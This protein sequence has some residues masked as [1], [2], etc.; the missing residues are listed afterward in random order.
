MEQLLHV[1][2]LS[3]GYMEGERVLHQITFDVKEGEIVALLGLNGAGKST[4]IKHILGFMKP[5]SGQIRIKGKTM[6]E[7]PE[8]YRHHYAYIPEMPIYYENLTL[9]EH[10][11]FAASIYGLKER[12][13]REKIEQLLKEFRMK[14]K[15]NLFP[16]YFSKGMKQ[17][18][19]IMIALL[20]RP[21]LY[22]IDEPLLGLDPVGI[23]SLLTALESEKRRGAGIFMSTHILSTA[24][25]YCDRFLILHQGKIIAQGSL[26]DLRQEVG[27]G[28]AT[29][30]DIYLQLIDRGDE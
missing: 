22:I 2:D 18:M 20:L 27:D 29:L 9:L 13:R 11:N 30:D 3:G 12:E 15:E 10:L 17:K 16:S 25:R 7:N 28:K 24:E 21:P 5:F 1:D 19:M 14:G 23:R 6:G 8:V 26:D 4:L